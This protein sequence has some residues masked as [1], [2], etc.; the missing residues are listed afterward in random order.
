[1]KPAASASSSHSPAEKLACELAPSVTQ[2]SI[3]ST[4]E[5]SSIE[6]P[7]YTLSW[8]TDGRHAGRVLRVEIPLVV[9]FGFGPGAPTLICRHGTS[10]RLK[11]CSKVRRSDSTPEMFPAVITDTCWPAPDWPLGAW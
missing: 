6:L 10:G 3:V 2:R 8:L 9:A 7:T 11:A 4:I 1:M 5:L